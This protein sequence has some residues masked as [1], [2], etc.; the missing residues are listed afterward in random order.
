MFAA[1]KLVNM[2]DSVLDQMIVPYWYVKDTPDCSD[3]NMEKVFIDVPVSADGKKGV[4]VKVPVL[5]NTKA[6]SAGEELLWYQKA[7]GKKAD[8]KAKATAAKPS[9]APKRTRVT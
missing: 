6:V 5:R 3:A 9:P 8:L 7:D 1:A 4:K 2:K